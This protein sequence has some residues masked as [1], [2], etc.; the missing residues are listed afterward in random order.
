MLSRTANSI[1]WLSR[2]IERAENVARFIDVNLLLMLDLPEVTPQHW[3]A[4]VFTTGDIEMFRERYDQANQANVI[5]FLAFDREN[6]NSL[7]S[8]IQKTRDNARSVLDYISYSMWEQINTFNLL[9]REAERNPQVLHTP[10]PFFTQ[11]KRECQLFDGIFHSTM[12]HGEA[13]HFSSLGRFLERADKTA[14][15]LDVRHFMPTTDDNSVESPFDTIQW[16]AVLKSVDALEMY[17]QRFRGVSPWRLYEFLMLD[18][19]FPRS[20][21]YC[22]HKAANSLRILIGRKDNYRFQNQAEQQLLKLC[23]QLE[24]ENQEDIINDN[25][26]ECLD[27]IQ[28]KLN[29]VHDHI[30]QLFFARRPFGES[31][32]SQS[33]T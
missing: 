6:P 32:Q 7:V 20:I 1:Y 13:W 8:T 9:L 11:F 24:Y 27:T 22:L 4:L 16:L 19:E 33:Q 30:H 18:K 29:T 14:R 12:S 21:L 2:Y 28:Q 15:L 10:D 3:E 25:L 17:R 23:C 26:H 5:R 31:S